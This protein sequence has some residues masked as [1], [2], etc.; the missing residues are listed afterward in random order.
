MISIEADGE[1]IPGGKEGMG[2]FA[3]TLR[4]N[5]GHAGKLIIEQIT[6]YDGFRNSLKT[7]YNE[8]MRELAEKVTGKQANYGAALLVGDAILCTVVFDGEFK[9]LTPDDILPCLATAEM[10]DTNEKNRDWLV[11]WVV[12]NIARFRDER[13]SEMEEIKGPVY[14]KIAANGDVAI[15]KSVLAEQMG[16]R[17]RVPSAFMNC[18][19]AQFIS[20]VSTTDPFDLSTSTHC[21]VLHP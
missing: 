17:G 8:N 20:P 12:T 11:G 6:E 16:N 13:H 4:E 21:V 19:I 15:L 3:D 7:T 9:P 18:H 1:L 14:G 10:V 5:Y 2:D